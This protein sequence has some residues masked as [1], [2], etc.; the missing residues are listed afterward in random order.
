[1]NSVRHTIQKAGKEKKKS[2]SVPGDRGRGFVGRRGPALGNPTP[3]ALTPALRTFA[4][5]VLLVCCLVTEA[6]AQNAPV[7]WTRPKA[8]FFHFDGEFIW[9]E[10]A[11]F[12]GPYPFFTGYFLWPALTQNTVNTIITGTK[13]LKLFYPQATVP[14]QDYFNSGLTLVNPS[15]SAMQT[16]RNKFVTM[17][18]SVGQRAWLNAMPEWDAEGGHWIKVANTPFTAST[19]EGMYTNFLNYVSAWTPLWTLLQTPQTT[20]QFWMNSVTDWVSNVHYSFEWGLDMVLMERAIDELGDLETGVA[21]LRGAATQYNKPW[22]IDIAA[23][24]T[25][26]NSPIT[27]NQATGKVSGG[28]SAEY[29]KRHT[30]IAYMAGANVIEYEA[31]QYR[32]GDGTLNP[33][34]LMTQAFYNFILAHPAATR[35]DPVV[36]IALM[37]D[38]YHGFVPKHWLN[39]P[40]NVWYTRLGYTNGDWMLENFFNV[41]WPGYDR[42]GLTTGWNGGTALVYTDWEDFHQ[43]MLAGNDPRPF[44]P[45]PTS[46]WGNLFDVLLSN[47]QPEALAKYRV[48]MLAGSVATTP[49]ITSQLSNYVSAG[50]TVIINSQQVS[51]SDQ[52]LLGVT[53]TGTT[54]TSTTSTWLP[55]STNYTENSYDY[56]LVTPTTATV[57]AS[58]AA[59]DP[60][61]TK[62]TIGS[63]S[64]YLVTPKYMQNT[65]MTGLLNIGLRLLDE[66]TALYREGWVT[67]AAPVDFLTTSKVSPS[68]TVKTVTVVNNSGTTWNGTVNVKLTAPVS[69]RE[70]LTNTSVSIGTVI[71]GVTTIAAT[72]PPYD[73]R[74]YAVTGGDQIAPQTPTGITIR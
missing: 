8:T 45:M 65:A 26:A 54:R 38:Y 39:R 12:T 16:E 32:Y 40:N 5:A 71:G 11:D 36:P 4:V 10:I 7:D 14:A 70:W 42:H 68:E 21:F 53:L 9:N 13:D 2:L 44:E 63:G 62:N 30:Y 15:P 31:S 69:A 72:V 24:R 28:F 60:L 29:I 59:G 22:G 17:T 50:G 55:T 58:N 34:G 35:G 33:Y 66:Q 47:A 23:F 20:R 48:V 1:M 6:V 64:V 27:Y 67:G 51:A 73:V 37:L 49:T 41:A 25:S 57:I 52:T 18:A 61:I 19:R 3:T 43:W 74:I 56:L 46:R